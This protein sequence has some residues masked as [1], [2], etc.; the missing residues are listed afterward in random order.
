MC[1]V[2]DVTGLMASLR[3]VQEACDSYGL[4]VARRKWPPYQW[5][6]FRPLSRHDVAVV[7]IRRIPSNEVDDLV[8]SWALS[9]A[10]E[11]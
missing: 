11:S 2:V 4:L 1:N 8:T 7:D 3:R 10:F 6:V 9:D 5:A